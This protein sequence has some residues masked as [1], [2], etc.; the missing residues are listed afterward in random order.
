MKRILMFIFSFIFLHSVFA[1]VHIHYLQKSVY[2][3]EKQAWGDWQNE[4][5]SFQIDTL[6]VSIVNL[7]TK[8]EL[9]YTR[10]ADVSGA[11]NATG[12]YYRLFEVNNEH[13]KHYE[14]RLFSDRNAGL[15][16]KCE[17]DGYMVQ[18]AGY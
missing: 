12:K 13:G 8:S 16:V 10:T 3:V 6:S 11:Y 17:E 9:K 2:D 1:V 5:N 7:S 18:Y 14:M 4:A 15:L